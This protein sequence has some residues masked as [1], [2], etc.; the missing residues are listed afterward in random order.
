[1]FRICSLLAAIFLSAPVLAD[2]AGRLTVIDGDTFD[3]GGTRV[4]L[5]G[6]DAPEHDQTCTATN[7]TVWDC[8][9]WVT[10]Q[11]TSLYDGTRATCTRLDTD[12]YDREVSRCSVN[13]DDLGQVLVLA[14]LAT[15]YREYAMDYDL[16]EKSAQVT[17]AGIWSG[18]FETPAEFRAEQRPPEQEAPGDCIIKGNISDSGRIFHVPGNENYE[19]TRINTSRGERWFCTEAEARAAGWRP[20]RN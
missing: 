8:G 19:D 15:A 18:T 10:T 4:R 11:V 9:A 2:S 3:V 1:M 14:G 6:V 16:A 7:G 13:G 12:R 17:G 20:A 5:F